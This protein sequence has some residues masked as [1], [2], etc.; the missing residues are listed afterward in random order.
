MI[1][2][3]LWMTRQLAVAALV[4]SRTLLWLAGSFTL[5]GQVSCEDDIIVGQLEEKFAP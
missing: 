4:S 3:N 1:D 5:K 2:S